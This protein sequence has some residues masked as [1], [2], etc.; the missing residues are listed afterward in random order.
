MPE[1]TVVTQPVVQP[2]VTEHNPYAPY[3]LD[4]Q[5]NPLT[6]KPVEKPVD[7]AAA[8]IAGLKETV[9]K[10][11]E[12]IKATESVTK[13]AAIVDKIIKAISG[14]GD[15]TDPKQYKAIFEDLKR[16]SP[17]GVRKALEML[18]NDPQAL[19]RLTGTVENVQ[20]QQLVGVNQLAHQRVVEL[21]S[22]AGFKAST[23]ADMNKMVF[24]FERAI[25]EVINA[26]PK[27]KEAFVNGNV[28]IIDEVFNSL[29][30]PHIA[31][32]LREKKSR[33][34]RSAVT[35]TPP[36]GKA[37]PQ[38]TSD[39]KTENKPDIRTPKGRAEFHKAASARFFDKIASRDEE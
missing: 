34:E 11:G 35:K 20:I 8:E 10:M 39:S 38:A 27:L 18:E 21:A 24:P 9:A 32:R 5:G 23:D 31:Q 1:E 30:S 7:P 28:E 36:F 25:T 12:Q 19:D 17:P 26:N 4:P 15:Q 33:Q 14:E 29:V 13:Q 37:Q 22:K 6:A 2:V 3:G 16:I